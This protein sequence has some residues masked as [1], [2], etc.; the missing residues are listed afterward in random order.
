MK[1]GQDTT[2][3]VKSL[4]NGEWFGGWAPVQARLEWLRADGQAGLEAEDEFY[5][6]GTLVVAVLEDGDWRAKAEVIP[7]A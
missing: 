3:Y 1:T 2:L 4:S 5:L 7:K 6:P